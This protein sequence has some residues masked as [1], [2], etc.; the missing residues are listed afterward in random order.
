MVSTKA[1]KSV[2][3]HTENETL[4]FQVLMG[5]CLLATINLQIMNKK[6][7][8]EINTEFHTSL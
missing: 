3:K 8:K 7:V 1:A 6:K 5:E 4:V 2:T